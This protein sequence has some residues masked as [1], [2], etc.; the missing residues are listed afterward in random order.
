MKIQHKDHCEKLWFYVTHIGNKE[1]ILG[2]SWLTKH[3]PS[4]N[5]QTND[6][7]FNRCPSECG[8]QP[9][10]KRLALPNSEVNK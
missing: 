3:N 5:W 2:H 6:I 8:L 7:T 1:I 9:F 10:A 4:I